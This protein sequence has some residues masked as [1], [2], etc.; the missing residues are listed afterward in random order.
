MPSGNSNESLS[1][2]IRRGQIVDDSRAEASCNGLRWRNVM[3]RSE[4]VGCARGER[5][6][7]EGVSRSA[8]SHAAH[9]TSF[10]LSRRFAPLATAGEVV[11]LE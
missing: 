6:S 4:G 10:T 2:I 7:G 5:S 9:N 3:H 8:V 11:G 1:K